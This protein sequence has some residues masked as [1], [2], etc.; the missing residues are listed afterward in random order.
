MS[1]KGIMITLFL[2]ALSLQCE[3]VND[4]GGGREVDTDSD[5]WLISPVFDGGP[6]KDGIPA[7]KNPE[8]IV[9]AEATYLR[10]NDLIIGIVEGDEAR[11]YP[12]A[13]LDWHE[14]INDG[15]GGKKFAIT[16]C[17]LTGTGI[18]FDRVIGNTETSFGVSG[19]LYENNLVPYDRATNSNWS[20]MLMECVN[21]QLI[22]S[23][24][25]VYQLIETSWST[26]KR[27]F[28]GTLVVSTN[29]G[30]GRSYG[31]YPYIRAGS[32]YRTDHGFVLF[33]IGSDDTRLRRKDRVH[34]II[35]DERTK[36]YPFKNLAGRKAAINDVV[37]G[38]PV[39]VAVSGPDNLIV[40]YLR[41]VSGV[42]LEFEVVTEGFD[43]YPF[44]LRSKDGTIWN[45]LGKAISGPNV[46]RQL[47]PTLSYN[48]YWF[49][50]GTFF[51]GADVFGQ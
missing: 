44:N 40:S 30:H 32:D 42:D 38:T 41:T 15:A 16:Y 5:E 28:P 7:L 6:G 13:I 33:P 3:A 39:V 4:L 17:P 12:H 24:V 2:A 21:G 10:E 22:R 46:G 43:V 9:A 31:I 1:T 47:V 19:L 35:V 27:M 18:A 29:T 36:V 37:N 45:I 34:G 14:I 8:M 11:A 25:R 23:R 20:Q 50:W 51:R 48:S 49:A 26:W